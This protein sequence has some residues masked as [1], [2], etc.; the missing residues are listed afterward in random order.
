MTKY[1]NQ[2]N[3]MFNNKII[4]KIIKTII[5]IKIKFFNYNKN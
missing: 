2:I 1:I 3:K 4:N 5:F